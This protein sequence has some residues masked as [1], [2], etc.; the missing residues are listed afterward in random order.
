MAKKKTTDK[1]LL[2]LGESLVKHSDKLLNVIAAAGV[3]YVGYKAFNHWSGALT[4]LLALQLVKSPNLAAGTAG[5]GTLA[6]LGAMNYASGY[7][8]Y[9]GEQHAQAVEVNQKIV[10]QCGPPPVLYPFSALGMT[11]APAFQQWT[12]CA[13]R[14][15][16]EW[17]QQQENK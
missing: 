6:A 16:R 8:P 4:G 15:A 7:Q 14:V 11:Q 5:V 10:E 3:G 1:A 17:Q 9:S 13:M 2:K 12:N